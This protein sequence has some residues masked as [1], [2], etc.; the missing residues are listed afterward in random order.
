MGNKEMER[1][2]QIMEKYFELI[3]D[4]GCDYDG[5]NTT[6]SLKS[7]I[8]ELCRYASLGRVANDT[9]VIYSTLEDKSGNGE[10]FNIL[11]EKINIDKK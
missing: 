9:E 10:V 6:E 3:I 7:L 5:F 1:Q 4:L 8:D 2:I 11:H